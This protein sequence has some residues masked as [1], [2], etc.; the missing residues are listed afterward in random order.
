MSI[1]LALQN[2]PVRG[3]RLLHDHSY[4]QRKAAAGQCQLSVW[5][6][7]NH[8]DGLR[9]LL[10]DHD[11]LSKVLSYY[12]SIQS[13]P[14]HIKRNIR[15]TSPKVIE[16][17]LGSYQSSKISRHTNDYQISDM[18]IKPEEKFD[19]ETNFITEELADNKLNKLSEEFDAKL[20][21]L[22]TNIDSRF[23]LLS[24][25]FTALNTSVLTLTSKVAE[26][27]S[28][29]VVLR[30]DCEKNFNK[31][32]DKINE[33]SFTGETGID[34]FDNTKTH[35]N[36]ND[37]TELDSDLEG[38]DVC[39]FPIVDKYDLI[40]LS[41]ISGNTLRAYNISRFTDASKST[42]TK[43]LADYKLACF[44]KHIMEKMVANEEP[45]PSL[46]ALARVATSKGYGY[47]NPKTGKPSLIYKSRV[48]R[49]MQSFNIP[50]NT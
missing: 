38:Y 21:N 2:Q 26:I 29:Q 18:S 30:L 15:T 8:Y 5:V 3:R 40:D 4:R 20:I 47:I 16:R 19:N 17:T 24:E 9:V 31:L 42:Q 50:F 35:S 46:R 32:N 23:N 11:V 7:K 33:Q 14:P 6:P 22:S 48:K 1:N 41:K 39:E 25:Q 45:T 27:S 12:Y 34:M 28:Q 13:N 10:T 36:N 43:F 37:S 44:C 49:V